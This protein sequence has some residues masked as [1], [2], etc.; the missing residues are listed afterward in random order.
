ML[1]SFL[2]TVL[3]LVGLIVTE[4]LKGAPERKKKRDALTT[5]SLDELAAGVD[6]VRGTAP[7]PPQ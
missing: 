4:Y 1:V 6:R 2:T 3:S 5:R 7:L